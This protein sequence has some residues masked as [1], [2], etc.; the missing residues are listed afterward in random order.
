M[1]AGKN[2][3]LFQDI[4]SDSKSRKEAHTERKRT[5]SYLGSREN[6]LAKMATGEIVDKAQRLIDPDRCKMWERHNRRYDLLNEQRCIDLIE[7]FKAQG[8]QE[9]PAVVRRLKD[10]PDYDYEVI[11]GARRHW[12]VS[13]LRNNNYPQFKFLIE[14]RNLT[15]EEAFRLSDIENRDK[16]DISDYERAQDYKSAL[17]SYYQTQK[18]MAERLEVSETWLSQYLDL[19]KLPVEVVECYYSI[20][21]IKTQHA[22]DL[23][24]LMKDKRNLSKL[25][26]EAK[27][28]KM[29]Q[30]SARAGEA[31]I[32]S[33]QEVVKR[34]KA[35]V[36][37]AKKA[38][39]KDNVLATYKSSTG[40]E[41]MSVTRKGKGELQ[42]SLR[43][44][45]GATRDEILEACQE[46]VINYIG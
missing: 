7:G 24:P 8:K 26:N 32:I 4:V 23:K 34:L 15:D 19:A 13:W 9:F 20:T 3:T 2:K 22:R 40:H 42:L 31:G 25:I 37:P 44:N 46:I 1:A 36:K 17:D 27:H 35:V 6:S 10:D 16:E 45:K 30:E 43:V 12:T 5:G 38:G 14:V 39:K 33:S 11:C 28:I 29:E 18:Q 21:D 41:F